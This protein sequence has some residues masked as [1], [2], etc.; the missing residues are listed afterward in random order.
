MATPS[1]LAALSSGVKNVFKPTVNIGP[2]SNDSISRGRDLNE[3]IIARALSNKPTSPIAG[4]GNLAS[5]WGA[6]RRGDKLDASEAQNKEAAEAKTQAAATQQGALVKALFEA[7]QGGN[8]PGALKTMDFSNPAVQH[9]ASKL[10]GQKPAERKTAT[11]QAGRLRY[12]DTGDNVF[13]DVATPQIERK[14]DTGPEGRKRYIDDGELVF[15]G[16]ETPEQAPKEIKPAE[17]IQDIRKEFSTESKTF[18]KTQD[19]FRRLLSASKEDSAS[20]DHAMIFSYMKTLDP[21]SVVRESEFD[22]AAS[23]GSMPQRLRAKA[24]QVISGERLNP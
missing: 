22:I 19:G 13:E 12:T 8:L 11:D 18:T 14:Y 20:G 23:L 3:H 9:A 7:Q 2:R 6:K 5:L 15:P 10:L 21:E 1:L 24:E 4:I 16:V 17:K